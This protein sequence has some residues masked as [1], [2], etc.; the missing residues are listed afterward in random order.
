MIPFT[1]LLNLSHSKEGFREVLRRGVRM[2]IEWA[3][4]SAIF[5]GAEIFCSKI[6]NKEDRWNAYI[7]SGI[8]TAS[9][10]IKVR[11]FLN[12]SWLTLC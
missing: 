3:Q 5:S 2:G 4:I 7:G 10:G 6:R 11:L 12:I 9:L 8:G 1:I